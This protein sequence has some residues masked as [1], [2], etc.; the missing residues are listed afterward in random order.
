MLALESAAQTGAMQLRRWELP[1]TDIKCP[2]SARPSRCNPRERG[3]LLP[4]ARAAHASQPPARSSARGEAGVTQ[5]Y[6]PAED[7]PGRSVAEMAGDA[8]S[9]TMPD[10]PTCQD[11]SKSSKYRFNG[12]LTTAEVEE[13]VKRLST[14]L[15]GLIRDFSIVKDS[16][17]H[18]EDDRTHALHRMDRFEQCQFKDLCIVSEETRTR[19]DALSSQ[20][21][22]LGAWVVETKDAQAKATE[23]TCKV[24]LMDARLMAHEEAVS[25]RIDLLDSRITARESELNQLFEASETGMLSADLRACSK[26]H[27]AGTTAAGACSLPADT[28]TASSEDAPETAQREQPATL[29]SG[30]AGLAALQASVEAQR[31]EFSCQLDLLDSRLCGQEAEWR[32]PAVPSVLGGASRPLPQVPGGGASARQASVAGTERHRPTSAGVETVVS[33]DPTEGS[34]GLRPEVVPM[35]S[36]VLTESNADVALD[37]Q[38]VTGC[39][40]GEAGRSA[41]EGR[42]SSG[43]VEV[44]EESSE[45][46]PAEQASSL[47]VLERFGMEPNQNKEELAQEPSPSR[48]RPWASKNCSGSSRV[49]PGHGLRTPSISSVE[50]L[51]GEFVEATGMRRGSSPQAGSPH[52]TTPC[53]W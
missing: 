29:N 39:R 53:R 18:L 9:W 23:V 52:F 42:R 16:V 25:C 37:V 8:S 10:R 17:W 21:G 22:D 35:A 20:V 1:Y 47:P 24:E 45:I 13:E 33:E 28:G 40:A 43:I 12:S 15:S 41:R 36:E 50:T 7:A 19:L 5:F 4:R 11:R 27:G 49:P 38:Q 31:R 48:G 26:N 34:E 44:L 6:D 14:L 51:A 30:L 46:A 2:A 32:Q 3:R